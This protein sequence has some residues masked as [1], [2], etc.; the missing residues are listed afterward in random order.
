MGTIKE[1]QETWTQYNWWDSGDEWSNG[2]G[3]SP[4]MWYSTILPRISS[5]L[6]ANKIL[7]IAPGFGRCTCF[8][9]ALCPDNLFVTVFS[10]KY[11]KNVYQWLESHGYSYQNHFYY[12]DTHELQQMKN[13][14]VDSQG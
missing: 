9:Q 12:F 4:Q 6:P 13:G 7:E 2:W 3:S 10:P 1:N 8:L 14:V 11:H 5:Y